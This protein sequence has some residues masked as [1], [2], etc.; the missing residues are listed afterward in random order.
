ML[1]SGGGDAGAGIGANTA[2]FSAVDAALLRPLPFRDPD[3]LAF[4][5]GRRIQSRQGGWRNRFCGLGKNGAQSYREPSR[6]SHLLC[7][8]I[9]D[10]G[11]GELEEVARAVCDRRIYC[12]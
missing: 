4:E 9:P 5:F 1:G 8:E 6:L 7:P 11:S 3:R 2:I 10:R 12:L